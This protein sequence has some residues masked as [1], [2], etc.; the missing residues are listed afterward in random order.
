MRLNRYHRVIPIEEPYF[1]DSQQKLPIVQS[2]DRI[3]IFI[4]PYGP[5]LKSVENDHSR[6]YF[7]TLWAGYAAPAPRSPRPEIPVK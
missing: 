5:P 6:P 3:K 7:G 1:A 4:P 2:L